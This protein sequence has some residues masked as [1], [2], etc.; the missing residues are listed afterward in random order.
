MTYLKLTFGMLFGEGKN[1]DII[2]ENLH[3]LNEHAINLKFYNKKQ[4]NLK[5]ID[6]NGEL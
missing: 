2:I 6:L 3:A 1:P 5:Q 4:T